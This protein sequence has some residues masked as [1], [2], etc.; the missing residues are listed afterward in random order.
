MTNSAKVLVDIQNL[1]KRFVV[2]QSLG[3]SLRSNTNRIYVMQNDSIST[4]EYKTFREFYPFYL[5]QHA[6]MVCRRLHF[7]GSLIVLAILATAIITGQL[8]WLIGLPIAGYGFAWVGHFLF[9]KNQPATFT[10]PI[11]S[12]MGDWL[13]F[14]EIL[15]GKISI[16]SS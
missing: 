7:M 3:L 13:M 15:S 14:W 8:V 12:L 6:N 2:E 10:Y 16:K 5:S 4:I 11:Y 1:E 9:E